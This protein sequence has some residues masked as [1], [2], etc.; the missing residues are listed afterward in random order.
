MTIDLEA[1]RLLVTVLATPMRVP[2][3]VGIAS[4]RWAYGGSRTCDA[5]GKSKAG[6][7][8]LRVDEEVETTRRH[9]EDGGSNIALGWQC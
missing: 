9:R 8:R 3:D 7:S 4:R 5:R 1:G 6:S 2:I